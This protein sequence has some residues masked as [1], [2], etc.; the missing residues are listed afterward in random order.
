[1]QRKGDLEMSKW[2]D[3]DIATSQFIDEYLQEFREGIM[4]HPDIVLEKKELVKVEH[5]LDAT[6]KFCK[7]LLTS[8]KGRLYMHDL[9]LMAIGFYGGHLTA[10][11][12]HGSSKKPIERN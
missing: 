10:Q 7:G 6:E 12:A 3:E 4:N 2:K 9:I 1:M 5:S 11:E 8:K